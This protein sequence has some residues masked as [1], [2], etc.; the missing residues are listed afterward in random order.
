MLSNF[1]LPKKHWL[2]L[3]VLSGLSVLIHL[4]PE[5]LPGLWDFVR[6]DLEHGAYWLLFSHALAHTNHFHL[7]LNLAGIV[8]LWALHGEYYS[9]RLIVLS[10][11]FIV[12]FSALGVW[13]LSPHIDNYV[14]LSAYLHGLFVIGACKDIAFKKITGSVLLLGLGIK[15]YLEQISDDDSTAR[16]IEANVAHDAHI[17]GAVGGLLFYLI[18]RGFQK[19]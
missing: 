19:V 8:L 9:T 7:L 11:L 17:Y 13:W 3:A 5:S 10:Y 4:L 2:A 16:L 12:P 6:E 18:L 14:G 15:L 1:P